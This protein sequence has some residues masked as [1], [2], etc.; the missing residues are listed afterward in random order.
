MLA[1]SILKNILV[2][3][4]AF[5][6]FAWSTV[7]SLVS[8]TPSKSRTGGRPRVCFRVR[9]GIRFLRLSSGRLAIRVVESVWSVSRLHSSVGG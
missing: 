9:L 4:T 2:L 6:S 8:S 7:M 3:S 5:G 1:E